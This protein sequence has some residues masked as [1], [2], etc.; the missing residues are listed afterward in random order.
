[1]FRLLLNLPLFSS[2]LL[3]STNA[4]CLR[5]DVTARIL[6]SLKMVGNAQGEYY[7]ESSGSFMVKEFSLYEELQ[8]IVD[9]ASQPIPE[10]PDGIVCVAK[11]TSATKDECRVTEAEYE[12]MARDNPASI[13]LRC[14][15]EYENANLLFGQA[16]IQTWPTFDIFYGG[17]RVARM[18]GSNMAELEELLKMYQFQNSELDLFSEASSEKRKLQW[19]DGTAKD[20]SKTPRTT[21]RFVPGYDWNSN[22]GFFDE[23]GD[24]AQQ[25]FDDTFGNWV[26]NI[27]DDDD[28]GGSNK[29]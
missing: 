11:Y 15:E 20:M 4:F 6:P 3:V 1:M 22:K 21:N 2:L 24:K 29:K 18:E 13:F 5:S 26:P 17:N 10:R 19:G 16:D 9:L 28:F 27:D 12:R 23:Q 14:F 7:G 25:S 8:E